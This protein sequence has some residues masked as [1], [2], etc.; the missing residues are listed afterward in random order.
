MKCL[1]CGYDTDTSSNLA[2]DDLKPEPGNISI[3][4]QCGHLMAFA[5]DMSFRELNDEEMLAVAGDKEI[6]LIQK[7]RAMAQEE[8]RRRREQPPVE[9]I[10][11]LFV[12]IAVHDNGGEGIVAEIT[13]NIPLISG[14]ERHVPIL[15]QAAMNALAREGK[16]KIVRFVA[17]EVLEEFG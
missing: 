17:T 11:E 6:L 14:R 3:C 9:K 12:V 16:M 1:A 13:K 15:R 2:D 4:I 8:L 10:T 7:A 5:D